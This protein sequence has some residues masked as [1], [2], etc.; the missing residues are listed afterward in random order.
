MRGGAGS[1]ASVPA[2]SASRQ[3]RALA[4][5]SSTSRMTCCCG[6]MRR[7][8]GAALSMGITST[9]ISPGASRSAM[10]CGSGPAAEPTRA[11]VSLSSAMPSPVAELVRTTAAAPATS[12]SAASEARSSLASATTHG[13]PCSEKSA[14]SWASVSVRP[15]TAST[16]STATSQVASTLRVASTRS[17]PRAPSSSKPGVSTMTTGPSG[18]SSMA[19][20]TGSVVVPA[21]SETTASCWPV[22]A[23]TRLD[24]PALRTP[25]NA[26]CTRSPLGVSLSPMAF[27]PPGT[28]NWGRFLFTGSII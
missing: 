16:T 11:S 23:F 28:C 22:T 20:R 24:L 7:P 9:T 18:S 25:K 4:P 3:M 17:S 27:P 8:L 5:A 14:S 12:G 15:R 13:M 2:S 19:L 26:I 10:S 21:T 6:R 1:A